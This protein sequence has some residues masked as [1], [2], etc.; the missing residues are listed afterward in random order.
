MCSRGQT[1]TV[2][3]GK[4]SY[5]YVLYIDEAGDDGLSRV[6]PV[7]PNGASEW[8][9]LSGYLIRA[10]EEHNTGRL[11]GEIMRDINCQASTLHY[12]KL[13]PTK[14]LRA[15]ELL[16]SKPARS[17][18]VASNKKNMRGYHNPRAA[19]AG[20]SQWFYNWLIRILLERVTD[21][22][23]T[24]SQGKPSKQDKIKI[25]FS[26]RGGHSYGQ[27]KAYL[28]LCRYQARP[29]LDRRQIDFRF[30]SYRLIDYV[31]HYQEAGLQ[32]ADI[33]A[34]AF[35][36]ALNPHDRRGWTNE[37]AKVLRPLTARDELGRIKDFGLVLQ[38]IN[39]RKIGLN[40]IQ[41]ELLVYYGFSAG[42]LGAGS[43]PV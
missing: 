37:P 11:L 8:L 5:N 16:C 31:P 25:V 36:Q 42:E 33:V 10:D 39:Y 26:K 30:I 27:T 17:F 38:P 1:L 15:A 41:K 6:F 29:Y 22:C 7:D 3:V 20:G 19:Q 24:L 14:Q 12:R 23:S 32:F 4:L 9:L 43:G 2:D 18:V 28:Q 40:K 13:G 34:S 21:F 35:Y